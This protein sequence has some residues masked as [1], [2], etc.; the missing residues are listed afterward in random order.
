[1]ASILAV[2][3]EELIEIGGAF[4]FSISRLQELNQVEAI[5]Q[6]W[7]T[8]VDGLEPLFDPGPDGLHMQANIRKQGTDVLA[9]VSVPV[10][11]AVMRVKALRHD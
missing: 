7:L 2:H 9:I 11:D 6:R 10:P 1:M 5:N 8:L 4:I 3:A